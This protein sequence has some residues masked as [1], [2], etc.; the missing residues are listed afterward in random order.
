MEEK[1]EKEEVIFLNL[2]MDYYE[3]RPINKASALLEKY[4]KEIEESRDDLA[5]KIAKRLV[6]SSLISLKEKGD[7]MYYK[8]KTLGF[9]DSEVADMLTGKE[10]LVDIGLFSTF[11]AEK[12]LQALEILKKEMEEISALF[13]VVKE[14]S[15]IEVAN[16]IRENVLPKLNIK[17]MSF[18]RIVEVCRERVKKNEKEVYARIGKISN[19][20]ADNPKREL[21]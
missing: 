3:N 17:E 5:Y 7:K 18:E 21:N 11:K 10:S 16:W 13:I 8:L 20:I 14:V 1:N 6:F 15:A 19:I 9:S 12:Y 4:K 2:K